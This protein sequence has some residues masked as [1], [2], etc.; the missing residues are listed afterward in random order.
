MAVNELWLGFL[1]FLFRS[2]MYKNSKLTTCNKLT[3]KILFTVCL[4]MD[5]SG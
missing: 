5:H 1:L 4:I 3:D 2:D